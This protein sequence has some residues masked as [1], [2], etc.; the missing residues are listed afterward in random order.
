MG[1]SG[2]STA[3]FQAM[4]KHLAQLDEEKDSI[5]HQYYPEVSSNRDDFQELIQS[6]VEHIERFLKNVSSGEIETQTEDECPFVLINSEVEV[7]DI[8]EKEV[9]RLRIVS[10]FKEEQRMEVECASYLSP[11]GKALLL[12]KVNDEVQV[13]TPMQTLQYK[14]KRIELDKIG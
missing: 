12:R 4:V 6:Y 7:E 13:K 11:I 1:L 10:P 14:I 5:L 3:T 8:N 9:F 2:I